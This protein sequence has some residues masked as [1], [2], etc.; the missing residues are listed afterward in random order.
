MTS[1]EKNL[2]LTAGVYLILVFIIQVRR[3]SLDYITPGM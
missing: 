2:D 1:L 3:R